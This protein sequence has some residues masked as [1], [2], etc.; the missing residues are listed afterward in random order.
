M[1]ITTGIE[2]AAIKPSLIPLVWDVV[3]PYLV[4]PIGHSNGELSLDNM[5]ERMIKGELLLLTIAENKNIMAVVTLEKR[6]FATG[7]NILNVTTAGGSDAHLWIE[8]LDEVLNNLAKD[9]DCQ[10][11]YIV[12]RDGWVRLLKDIGYGKIH[13]VVSKKVEV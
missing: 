7:K 11:I 1:I 10:E 5:Y 4:A 12:G 9:Y 3:T 8:Q 2:I 6:E 13:T